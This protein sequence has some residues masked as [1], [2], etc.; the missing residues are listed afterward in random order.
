MEEGRSSFKDLTGKRHL[1]RLMRRWDDNIRMDFKEID[2]NTRSW[3]DSDQDRGCL[4]SPCECG[5][6]PSG[7]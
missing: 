4:E 5:I 7:S 2:I 3:V 6:E 1:G